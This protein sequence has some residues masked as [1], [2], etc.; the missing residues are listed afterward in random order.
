MMDKQKYIENKQKRREIKKTDRR[1]ATTEEVIFIFEKILENWKTIRIF[2]TIIQQNPNST[3]LKKNVENIS[4]G[5]CKVYENELSPEK[6][7]YYLELRDKVY[8]YHRQIKLSKKNID[9]SI[10]DNTN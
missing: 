5:N 6:Y 4:T 8:N 3:I 10:A 7:K 1:N 9:I 2:N